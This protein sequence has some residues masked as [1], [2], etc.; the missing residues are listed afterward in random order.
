MHFRHVW[1][2]FAFE[3][4]WEPMKPLEE[5]TSKMNP[6]T[7]TRREA[8]RKEL[9]EMHLF[10]TE[11]DEEKALCGED[12]SPIELMSVGYYL[13]ERLFGRPVGTVC[14]RCKTLAIPLATVILEDMA[15][16]FEDEG[17][18]GDAED[19]RDLLNTLAR[20]TGWIAGR[21]GD[22]PCVGLFFA[23]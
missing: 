22:R 5:T 7:G 6:G 2:P 20:E 3:K 8:A 18:L 14:E 13:E 17:R 11:A 23:L 9:M 15:E 19:C 1:G 10:D 4:G 21:T 12:S 16:D